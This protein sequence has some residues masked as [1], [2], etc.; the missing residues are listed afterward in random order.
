MASSD[1]SERAPS[2]AVSSST[3][4]EP[5]T[6]SS[7][8]SQGPPAPWVGSGGVLQCGI[9]F[10]LLCRP[11]ALLCGH[12][13][14]RTCLFRSMN[15]YGPCSCCP[16]CRGPFEHL[17][18]VC[19]ALDGTLAALL[20]RH[21]TARL[22][23]DVLCGPEAASTAAAP[24]RGSSLRALLSCV[25]CTRVLRRPVVLTCGHSVCWDCARAVGGAQVGAGE[26][27]P[28]CERVPPGGWPSRP[29]LVLE[30]VVRR[31]LP[32][33]AVDFL[34]EPDSPADPAW[35]PA[36]R[37]DPEHAQANSQR[38]VVRRLQDVQIP[39]EEF[40]WYHVGC[41]GC[42][43]YP[44]RGRRFQC[45]HPL[46]RRED[47]GNTFDLCESCHARRVCS[48]GRFGQ[49]HH[50]D[51]VLVEQAQ[52][53]SELHM[54]QWCNPELP[55]S[56]LRELLDLA[57]AQQRPQPS[58]VLAAPVDSLQTSVA[59]VGEAL[60]RAAQEMHALESLLRRQTLSLELEARRREQ[61]LQDKL[62]EA[63]ELRRRAVDL[64]RQ[65]EANRELLQRRQAEK[66]ALEQRH[67]R[68][69][70]ASRALEAQV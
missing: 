35:P 32:S 50:L 33:R 14:C 40:V 27:C 24:E 70:E 4:T 19:E 65:I 9:C 39:P 51:H 47:G 11:V 2:A 52:V 25:R 43:R 13:A 38:L 10:E 12:T 6:S 59:M 44:L 20:S 42:G 5:S 54:L 41:D 68:Q 17:P 21:Y 45:T 58:A 46:C 56:R 64:Q 37:V 55:A 61:Q 36:Q 34:A 7:E 23:E 62:R 1:P 66:A 8:V 22:A 63:E 3:P 67:A 57:V 28:R 30:E 15:G 26:T 53:V 48:T 16:F 60:S 29:C 69:L 31:L 49:N 18:T